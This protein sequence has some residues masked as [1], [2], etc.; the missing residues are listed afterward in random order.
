MKAK[1]MGGKFCITGL[2]SFKIIS[3]PLETNGRQ[4]GAD[5]MMTTFGP[6]IRK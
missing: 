2:V 3:D 1:K 5:Y 6:K 4:N